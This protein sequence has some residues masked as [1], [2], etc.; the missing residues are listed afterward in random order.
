MTHVKMRSFIAPGQAVL[1]GAE[2]SADGGA[3]GIRLSATSDARVVA[4]ARLDLAT[5]G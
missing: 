1:L 2:L 5:R 3:D 4:T